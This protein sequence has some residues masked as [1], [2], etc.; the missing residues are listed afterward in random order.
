MV[1]LAKR[2]WGHQVQATPPREP[3]RPELDFENREIYPEQPFR[4]LAPPQTPNSYTL[5][6]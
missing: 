2:I 6:R 5:E 1:V 4:S 3:S